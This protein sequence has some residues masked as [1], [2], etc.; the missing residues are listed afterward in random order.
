MG[1][2]LCKVN[3]I[4]SSSWKIELLSVVLEMTIQLYREIGQ[5]I[6]SYRKSLLYKLHL[7]MASYRIP[8]QTPNQLTFSREIIFSV[9][10]VVPVNLLEAMKCHGTSHKKS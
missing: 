5:R 4:I 2:L 3:L 9:A 1:V 8:L 10:V 7:A 6:I